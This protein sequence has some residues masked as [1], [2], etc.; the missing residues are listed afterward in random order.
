[1]G[2]FKFRIDKLS[3]A[4]RDGRYDQIVKALQK[5]GVDVNER[6]K[7]GFTP[8]YEASKNGHPE[9]VKL[10]LEAGVDMNKACTT[11]DFTPLYIASKDGHSEVVKLL[12]EAGAVDSRDQEELHRHEA[13]AVENGNISKEDFLLPKTEYAH[14]FTLGWRLGFLQIMVDTGINITQKAN[15]EKIYNETINNIKYLGF[16][17]NHKLEIKNT[18]ETIREKID[19]KNPALQILYSCGLLL[20]DFLHPQRPL[21]DPTEIEMLKTYFAAFE[22]NSQ[23]LDPLIDAFKKSPPPS[24][25]FGNVLQLVASNIIIALNEIKKES[26]I[27]ENS[28]ELSRQIENVRFLTN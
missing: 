10:L 25:D 3:L 8:L 27:Q 5:K 18:I 21:K 28:N 19:S 2:F 26:V 7:E 6:D 20:S 16:Q 23:I 1:M 15:Y 17:I 11:D 22:I 9:I 24:E 13:N 14:S 12:L 4:V